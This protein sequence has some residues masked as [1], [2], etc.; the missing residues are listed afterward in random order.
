MGGVRG[1]LPP[2]SIFL[3]PMHH[4]IDEAVDAHVH[5]AQSAPL[6]RVVDFRRHEHVPTREVQLGKTYA[7]AP[8]P[9]TIDR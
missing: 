5:K 8:P 2:C 3:A 6:L 1:G 4:M 7:Y 9:L